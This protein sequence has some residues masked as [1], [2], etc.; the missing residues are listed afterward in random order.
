MKEI[1]WDGCDNAYG[2]TIYCRSRGWQVEWK[3]NDVEY[4]RRFDYF[5][6]AENMADVL[7]KRFGANLACTPDDIES[8][9]A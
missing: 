5:Y 2:V 8:T 4:Y 3:Y 6:K 1:N 9:K 7:I